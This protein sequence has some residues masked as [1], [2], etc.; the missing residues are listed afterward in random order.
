M[1][2]QMDIDRE[3]VNGAS[4]P[5][6]RSQNNSSAQTN[7]SVPITNGN[8]HSEAPAPPPHR[9]NPSSPVPTPQDDA[10]SYKAAG[11]KFFKEKNYTKAI[12]QY[13][14]GMTTCAN[15]IMLQVPV[16]RHYG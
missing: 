13:S 12:E 16:P 2:D 11:N 6:S 9:S 4:S 8:H 10:E 7:F 15:W 5:A 1:S 3:P 14:K